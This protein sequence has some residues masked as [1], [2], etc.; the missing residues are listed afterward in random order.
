L[1]RNR[2][3]GTILNYDCGNR[4]KERGPRL[5]QTPSSRMESVSGTRR[6]AGEVVLC[7]V[8]AGFVGVVLAVAL[9]G[10]LFSRP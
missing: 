8:V 7:S 2:G 10:S 1:T 5:R 9:V 6:R 4:A 3:I